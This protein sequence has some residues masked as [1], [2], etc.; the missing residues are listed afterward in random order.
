MGVKIGME[1][2]DPGREIPGNLECSEEVVVPPEHAASHIG[3]GSLQVLSTPCMILYMES[4]A[5]RCLDKYLPEEYTTVGVHVDVYH[6]AP[7]PIGAKIVVTTRL[8]KREGRRL[9]LRVEARLGDKIIG[10]GIHERFIVNRGRFLE[11]VAQM[12]VKPQ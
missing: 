3:S 8:V 4:L 9:V 1:H 7:A 11:K 5:R 6:R 2:S 12:S 10:E